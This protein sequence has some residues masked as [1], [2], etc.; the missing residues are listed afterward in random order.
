LSTL[1]PAGHLEDK[2]QIVDI[3]LV[4]KGPQIA[5][6]DSIRYS[7]QKLFQLS[8]YQTLH[9]LAGHIS[10]YFQLSKYFK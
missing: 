5:A 8:L 4:A 3:H 10:I 1:K 6:I 9:L 7:W 2:Y